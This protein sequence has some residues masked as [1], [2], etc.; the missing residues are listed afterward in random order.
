MG[1]NPGL[2]LL[3][4]TRSLSTGSGNPVYQ[5]LRV[6]RHSGVIVEDTFITRRFARY[7]GTSTSRPLHGHLA[8]VGTA[9]SWWDHP[10]EHTVPEGSV[11]DKGC[12]LLSTGRLKN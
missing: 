5:R 8:G 3:D 4:R 11:G 9:G 7:E 12:I 10:G 2:V 1:S 6:R